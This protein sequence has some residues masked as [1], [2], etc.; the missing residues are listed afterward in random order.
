MK[1]KAD[2][3]TLPPIWVQGFSWLFALYLIVPL[4]MI[5][6]SITGDLNVA[7]L[8]M[9]FEG[10][11]PLSW[12]M[13]LGLLFFVAGLTA[14]S[15]LSNRPWA[16]DFGIIYTISALGV[17]GVG[18]ILGA[19]GIWTRLDEV[20]VCVTALI[21]FLCHLIRNRNQWRI[22]ATEKELEQIAKQDLS[23]APGDESS[24]D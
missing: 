9:S 6:Q 12:I 4:I 17:T 21:A 11:D 16:Y 5:A 14:H 20:A 15:I 10:G 22:E 24:L 13:I 8:G 7:L 3:H 19:G 23:L 2:S 18:L 1:Q